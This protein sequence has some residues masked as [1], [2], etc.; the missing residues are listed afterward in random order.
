MKS[1]CFIVIL[2]VFIPFVFIS[3][4]KDK[5]FVKPLVE[6]SAQLL[7]SEIQDQYKVEDYTHLGRYLFT[8]EKKLLLKQFGDTSKLA[9][10][11]GN[12]SFPLKTHKVNQNL[13]VAFP[14]EIIG[15]AAIENGV[16]KQKQPL[17]QRDSDNNS[18][19]SLEDV[20][21][22]GTITQNGTNTYE[23]NLEDYLQL[24][25]NN[26]S[27]IFSN[28]ILIRPSY[29]KSCE[30][31]MYAIRI[32]YDARQAASEHTTCAAFEFLK[33]RTNH[34][35]LLYFGNTNQAVLQENGS[36]TITAPD[37]RDR[38]RQIGTEGELNGNNTF[39]IIRD[40]TNQCYVIRIDR[41]VLTQNHDYEDT[42][43]FKAQ[44]KATTDCEWRPIDTSIYETSIPYAENAGSETIRNARFSADLKLGLYGSDGIKRGA[45]NSM[46]EAVYQAQTSDT[47]LVNGPFSFIE[48]TQSYINDIELT[49]LSNDAPFTLDYTGS[50]TRA[51]MIDGSASLTISDVIIQNADITYMGAA[52]YVTGTTPSLTIRDSVIGTNTADYFGGAIALMRGE[53]LIE[54]CTLTSNTVSGSGGALYNNASCTIRDSFISQNHATSIGGSIYN[55]KELTFYRNIT[56][57][58]TANTGTNGIFIHNQ[59]QVYSSSNEEW[60]HFN[61]PQ[62]TVRII[63]KKDEPENSYSDQGDSEGDCIYVQNTRETLAGS[64]K[65]IPSTST[66]YEKQ[67][68]EIRY[69]TGDF[70]CEGSITIDIPENFSITDTSTVT[71]GTDDAT[72][73]SVYTHDAHSITVGGL[74]GE[75][76]VTV[77]LTIQASVPTGYPDPV[78]S[79]N[80]I[81][82]FTAISDA[83]GTGN[84]WSSS[85]KSTA[86]F[87][88][89]NYSVCTD[90]RI[91]AEYTYLKLL[92]NEAT[93]IQY[94]AQ[95]AGQTTAASITDALESADGSN[96]SYRI[97]VPGGTLNPADILPAEATLTVTAEHGNVSEFTVYREN[98]DFRLIRTSGKYNLYKTLT[99]AISAAENGQKYTI[100]SSSTSEIKEPELV[101]NSTKEIIIKPAANVSRITLNGNDIHRVLSVSGNASVTLISTTIRMGRTSADGGGIHMAG[102]KL[103]LEN[104]TV[105]NNYSSTNGGG[106]YFGGGLL[107]LS[108]ITIQNNNSGNNGGGIYLTPA[109]GMPELH[110]NSGSIN[111]NGATNYGG[112]IYKNAGNIYTVNGQWNGGAVPMG[113]GQYNVN[114]SVD[115]QG[116]C[117]ENDTSYPAKVYGNSAAQGSQ[118][119]M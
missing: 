43:C 61:S 113:P 54:G 97:D 66:E 18:P 116:T 62:A 91:K 29:I 22:T 20:I 80:I 65:L 31:N 94:E 37:T 15:T 73:A 14:D 3:C 93:P 106:I 105:E 90:V 118:M 68:I 101:I 49:I 117:H 67:L 52:F 53:T 99:E 4:L 112:G 88:S 100:E 83:D 111:S 107:T 10:E 24:K 59:S 98:G 119:M 78:Q 84:A 17:V 32:Y 103:Y 28:G 86:N 9:L 11:I 81:Y 25:E 50:A 26:T 85:P 46:S 108:N 23:L 89:F 74:N 45:Y 69:E 33:S 2:C 7:L 70:F 102:A 8:V 64:L 51:F 104:C 35:Q 55:L 58:N 1:K 38:L 36:V 110:F 56:T 60:R 13:M 95:T 76:G 114:F 72:E 87:E 19:L 109:S 16:I 57:S 77:K 27:I 63:E 21:I 12:Y 75:S 5:F 79:R 6:D 40:D 115:T 41:D 92:T 47:I 48:S 39:Q 34:E 42:Y 82:P 44:L 30:N 96:Q 71:I